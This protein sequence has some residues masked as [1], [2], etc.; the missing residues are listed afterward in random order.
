MARTTVKKEIDEIRPETS[1]TEDG[2]FPANW[3]LA[4]NNIRKM[5]KE[6]FF[7]LR[8][9]QG[10]RLLNFGFIRSCGS[11]LN[12]SSESLLKSSQYSF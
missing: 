8:I 1:I 6:V 11:Y 7:L 2:W 10:H 9:E 5:R 4:L 12:L 3:E